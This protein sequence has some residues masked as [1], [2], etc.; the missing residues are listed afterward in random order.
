MKDVVQ[1][2]F[3]VLE[4]MGEFV[5]IRFGRVSG[6]SDEVDWIYK[7]HHEFDGIGGFAS[8]LRSK[9]IEIASLPETNQ[10]S[11]NSWLS[12]LRLLPRFLGFRKVLQISQDIDKG[13]LEPVYSAP[14]PA[15][16]WHVFSEDETSKIRSYGKSAGVTVN[17]L[18]LKHVSEVTRKH[19]DEPSEKVPWMIPV[20]LRGGIKQT[21]DTSNIFSYIAVN[22]SA[23]DSIK[24]IHNDIYAKLS[25]GEHWGT[26]KKYKMGYWLPIFIKKWLITSNRAVLQWNLGTFSNLGAWDLSEKAGENTDKENWV[27]APPVTATQMIGVGCLT[28]NNRLSITIQLHPSL[29]TSVSVANAFLGDFVML[30]KRDISQNSI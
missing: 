24:D 16:A 17:S 12:L 2:W 27:F 10:L 4:E 13:A 21:P 6:S 14:T 25:N 22:V 28:T 3:E 8:I 11:N 26:Y 1:P 9:G 20:N 5:G 18:L 19:L 29:T 23:E 30:V 15:Y 7:P